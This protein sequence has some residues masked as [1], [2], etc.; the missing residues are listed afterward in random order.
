MK[1]GGV[2]DR[3]HFSILVDM[4]QA[5]VLESYL[6]SIFKHNNLKFQT[7]SLSTGGDTVT[8]S[9]SWFLVSVYFLGLKLNFLSWTSNLGKFREIGVKVGVDFVWW[10]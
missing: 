5:N 8:Y 4:S 3:S 2:V 9:V 6:S 7:P 10:L 1:M